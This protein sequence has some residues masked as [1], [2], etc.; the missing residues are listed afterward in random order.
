MNIHQF[1]AGKRTW[2]GELEDPEDGFK[3]E[4]NVLSSWT[5]ACMDMGW[6]EV[7]RCNEMHICVYKT[8]TGKLRI[9]GL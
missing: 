1:L 8:T 6:T 2:K 3:V 9:L 7:F 4:A 5:E